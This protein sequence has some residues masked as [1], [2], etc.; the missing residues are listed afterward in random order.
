MTEEKEMDGLE[1][2]RR[3]GQRMFDDDLASRELGVVVEI[4]APGRAEAEFEVRANMVNGH[5]ICHGGYIFT[6]A[7]SAFAFA[8]NTYDDITV[9][10]AASIEFLRPAKLG[11][12]LRAVASEQH[13]GRRNGIYDVVVTNQDGATV[14]LFRGRSHST[15]E[16]FLPPSPEEK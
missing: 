3:C 9:A 4:T 7:D 8:C 6:L 2:A 5:D 1:L 16:P 11:D 14:A 13:R 12:R 15:G 10:A